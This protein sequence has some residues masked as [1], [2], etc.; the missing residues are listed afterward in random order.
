MSDLP[1]ERPVVR[2]AVFALA[3]DRRR[4]VLEVLWYIEHRHHWIDPDMFDIDL[5]DLAA[6][7][8]MFGADDDPAP[9][10]I[11]LTFDDV[12]ALETCVMAADAYTHRQ[13]ERGLCSLTDEEFAD[14]DRWMSEA[15]Q[16]FVTQLGAGDDG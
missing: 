10:T 12:V 6:L 16:C 2:R 4:Q 1:P 5:D 9:A 11:S 3:P 13:G 14:I 7:Q 15:R 8:Q